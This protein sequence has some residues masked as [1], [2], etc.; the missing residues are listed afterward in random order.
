MLKATKHNLT[1][2]IPQHWLD[3]RGFLS[4]QAVYT[5]KLFYGEVSLE[6]ALEGAKKTRKYGWTI[7]EVKQ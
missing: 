6:D 1:L 3:S 2:I 5:L 7:K 4:T